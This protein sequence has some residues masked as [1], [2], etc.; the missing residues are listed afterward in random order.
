MLVFCRAS[1]GL[2][3]GV[4][5]RIFLQPLHFPQISRW[6]PGLDEIQVWLLGCQLQGVGGVLP[7][8]APDALGSS[9]ASIPEPFRGSS[10]ATFQFCHSVFISEPK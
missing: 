10:L 5:V 8:E 6:S 1:Y 3:F 7:P 2:D 9:V 4:P